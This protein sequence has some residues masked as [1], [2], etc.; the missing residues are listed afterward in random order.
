MSAERF[1]ATQNPESFAREIL[2]VVWTVIVGGVSGWMDTPNPLLLLIAALGADAVLVQRDA[3]QRAAVDLL[4]GRILLRSGVHAAGEGE[5][6]DVQLVLEQVVD[7]LDHALN[8]HRLL[9]HHQTALG[10][11]RGQLC[12]ERR[13]L[14]LVG[15][16]AVADALRLINAEDRGEQRIVLPQEPSMLR[17]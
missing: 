4:R 8:R 13:A 14:H 1:L 6:C 15:W 9:R 5:L 10:I 7:D 17:V 12:F 3:A 11:G 16:R 2:G